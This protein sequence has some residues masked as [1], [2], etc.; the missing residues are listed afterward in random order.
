[1]DTYAKILIRVLLDFAVGIV[2][3]NCWAT[4]NDD[5]NDFLSYDIL[6]SG[7]P[8]DL[9]DVEEGILKVLSNGQS[10]DSGFSIESFQFQADDSLI[11]QL[12]FH[13]DVQL[14]S[15]NC[16]PSCNA[17]KRRSN[18]ASTVKMKLGPIHFGY[19]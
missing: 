16:E 1:M 10:S 8:A 2:L 7:C 4:P 14:C 13:C 15:E 9:L 3:E 19:P 17:R 12:Y 5:P 11:K 6:I 18:V